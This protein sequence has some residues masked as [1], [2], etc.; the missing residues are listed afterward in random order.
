MVCE[1]CLMHCKYVLSEK[2]LRQKIQEAFPQNRLSTQRFEK[3]FQ[4]IERKGKKK[5]N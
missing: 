5:R 2:Q 4:I 3:H 1:G